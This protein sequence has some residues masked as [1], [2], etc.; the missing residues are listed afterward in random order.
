MEAQQ[1]RYKIVERNR[2]LVTIDLQTGKEVGAKLPAVPSGLSAPLGPALTPGPSPR[3]YVAG[4]S[5]WMYTLAQLLPGVKMVDGIAHL[6]TGA[7][8]D[9]LAPRTLRLTDQG[10]RKLGGTAIGLGVALAIAF[11]LWMLTGFW[12]VVI[13][14]VVLGKF[15]KHVTKAVMTSVIADAVEVDIELPT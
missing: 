7:S 2:R 1:G 12:I 6:K 15:G 4:E 3:P 11:L 10:V 13:A 8:Y 9:A 5:D 14:A